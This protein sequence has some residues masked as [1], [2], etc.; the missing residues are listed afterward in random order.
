MS[1]IL[2]ISHDCFSDQNANGKTLKSLLSHYDKSQLIQF[3]TGVDSPDFSKAESYFRVTDMQMMKSF[4]KSQNYIISDTENIADTGSEVKVRNSLV[5]NFLKKM[6]YNFFFRNSRELLWELS[7]S[8]RKSF[9]KWIEEHKPNAILYMVGDSFATDKLVQN[10]ARRYNLPIILFNV[11]AYKIINL[12][13]RKWL[14]RLFYSINEKS[15][16]KFFDYRH[17]TIYNSKDLKESYN[18]FY[19][20]S[21]EQ[22]LI[23]Y[24]TSD[25]DTAPY[26]VKQNPMINIVYFGNLGVGRVG[27]LIDIADVLKAI[28]RNVVI[29]VYGYVEGNDKHLL[30]SHEQINYHGLVS[31]EELIQIKENAD[32]L[33]QVESFDESIREKLRFAF[34]TKIAQCLCSGRCILSYAPLETA[35]TQYLINSDAAVVVTNKEDLKHTLINLISDG[36]LRLVY[37]NKAIQIAKTNHDIRLLGKYV[38]DYINDYC[39][40]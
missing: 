34:S 40:N 11:E 23:V 36:E 10:I 38:Y 13:E 19:G 15:Y 2:V 5:W 17:L 1:K 12:K 27:S 14:D 29:D 9:Y 25:F 3:Y 31:A 6:N 16:R 39:Q 35:S 7:F 8:W 28:D 21:D 33:L 26:V 4:F 22:S 24:N 30:E 37:S 32:I 20:I 18:E